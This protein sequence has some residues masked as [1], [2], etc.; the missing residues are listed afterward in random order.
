MSQDVG[1]FVNSANNNVFIDNFK[2]ISLIKLSFLNLI[3]IPQI[4]VIPFFSTIYFHS[5]QARSCS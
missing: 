1:I 3:Q 5:I 2:T 4:N